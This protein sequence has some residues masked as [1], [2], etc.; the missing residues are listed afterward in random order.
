MIEVGYLYENRKGELVTISHKLPANLGV[1]QYIGDN[2]R[3]YTYRGCFDLTK[4]NHPQDLV[5]DVIY[6]SVI[7]EVGKIYKN[8]GGK[9][10]AIVSIEEGKTYPYVCGNGYRY[11]KNGRVSNFMGASVGDLVEEVEGEEE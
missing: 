5:A 7:L 2:G 10:V 8:R 6:T 11:K 4:E 1:Y 9:I 3:A